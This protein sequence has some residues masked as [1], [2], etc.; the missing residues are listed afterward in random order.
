MLC[1]N[2]L[3]ENTL[4]IYQPVSEILKAMVA[5]NKSDGQGSRN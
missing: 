4:T 1:K 2:N 5:F 3:L